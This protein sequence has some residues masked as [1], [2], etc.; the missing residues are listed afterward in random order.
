MITQMPAIREPDRHETAALQDDP[1]SSDG[2]RVIHS[3]LMRL[4]EEDPDERTVPPTDYAYRT[5]L[6][7][8]SETQRLSGDLPRASVTGDETGGL[9]VQWIGPERQV[10]LVIPAGSAGRHYVYHEAGQDYEL[11]DDPS[12]A[13][14]SE[15]LRWC[16]YEATGFTAGR[17]TG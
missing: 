8:L 3:R 6:A 16:D 11:V 15:R 2:F 10:R 12:P 13:L 7:V 9:R 14:L 4:L 1:A 17:A 5:A